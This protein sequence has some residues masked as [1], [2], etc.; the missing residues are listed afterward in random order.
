MGAALAR[1]QPR[2][3]G[4][5]RRGRRGA[6]PEPVPADARRAGRRAEADR[7]CAAG[8]HGQFARGVP[9]ARRFD[10]RRG[11]Q[12]RRR[13]QPRRIFG[14]VRGRLVR[15]R[16]HGKAAEAAR[17]GDAA[18]GAGRRRARW[19]RCSAPTSSSR[20]RSP[21]PRRKARCA[22]VA[23]D[24]DPSQVVISGHKGAIDRA[25]EMAKEMGAKRAVAAAGLGAVPLP[26]DAAGGRRDERCAF[27][28]WC[29]SAG[30]AALRQCHGRADDRSRHDPQPAG[31]AGHRHGPLARERRQHG[32]RG[33]RGIRRDRR[34]GARPD[35]QAHRARRKGDERR[36][37]RGHRSA[38]EGDRSRCSTLRE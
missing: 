14:A 20:R 12:L 25:I 38:G 1:G 3:A 35:G 6:R 23:N 15:P 17:A 8:D 16:D 33:R 21:T 7:E 13:P 36:H 32:R 11:G 9:D 18:G 10:L 28:T 5:V 30:G 27:A 4:R 19:R 29:S 26:A 31:R 22:T 24:N 37:H 34:Q 2:R